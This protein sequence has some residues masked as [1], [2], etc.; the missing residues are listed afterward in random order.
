MPAKVSD[1]RRAHGRRVQRAPTGRPSR[2]SEIGKLEIAAERAPA[3]SSEGNLSE[4]YLAVV[5]KP[6]LALRFHSPMI[7]VLWMI[8]GLTASEL[9][10]R[11]LEASMVAVEPD[12]SRA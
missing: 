4:D 9:F 1:R 6:H 8:M 12:P 2:Q 3:A 5:L 11:L 7:A 10:R